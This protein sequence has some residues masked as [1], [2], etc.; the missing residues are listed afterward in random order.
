LDKEDVL[1]QGDLPEH[2][3]LYWARIVVF[4]LL[5]I[6]TDQQKWVNLTNV[7]HADRK[8]EIVEMCWNDGDNIEVIL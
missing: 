1:C 3:C 2:M 8:N 7:H 5:G 4:F 6:D